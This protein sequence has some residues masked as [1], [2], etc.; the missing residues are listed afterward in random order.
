MLEIV[1]VPRLSSIKVDGKLFGPIK[2]IKGSVKRERKG[3]F[4][5]TS[6]APLHEVLYLILY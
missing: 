2:F 1:L 5:T 3:T 4:L 6:R